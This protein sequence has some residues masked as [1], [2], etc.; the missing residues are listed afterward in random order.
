MGRL[1]AMMEVMRSTMF[2]RNTRSTQPPAILQSSAAKTVNAS[3]NP[4]FAITWTIAVTEV[5][6]RVSVHASAT[7][8]QQILA[9]YVTESDIAGT[10]LTRILIIAVPTVRQ[11]RSCVAGELISEILENPA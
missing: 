3:K 1:I 5:T 9:N 2:A 4:T 11:S 6:N 7:F 8:E 10:E